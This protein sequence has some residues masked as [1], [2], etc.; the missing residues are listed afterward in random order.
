MPNDNEQRE[1]SPCEVAPEVELFFGD[2]NDAEARI[3]ARL[4]SNAPPDGWEITGVV[5]GP[6]CRFAKT[7]P[8]AIR[9]RSCGPG[10]GPLAEAI[11]PDPCFWTPDLP[12]LYRCHLEVGRLPAGAKPA[13][14]LAGA[15]N[16]FRIASPHQ[17]GAVRGGDRW[18]GIR[19]WGTIG[20][21]LYLDAKRWVPRGVHRDAPTA[22]DLAAA[23]EASAALYVATADDALCLAA[24]QLGVP[25]FVDLRGA[26]QIVE[27]IRRL[28]QWPAVFAILLDPTFPCGDELRA[29]ARNTLFAARIDGPASTQVPSWAQA[30]VCTA[31]KG[32]GLP[33][34]ARQSNVPLIVVRRLPVATSIGEA[35]AACDRL[36]FDLAPRGDFAGYFV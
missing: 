26:A 29:A 17:P 35:R 5:T 20:R 6:T 18:L 4:L 13:A 12:F 28:G 33:P 7:L 21:S 14:P 36:Q 8:A 34:A 9:F 23:R 32:D 25:L 1:I 11:V 24:S 22:A 19:R 16:G 2:A 3:Y 27:E 30:I 15:A 31:E 10:A